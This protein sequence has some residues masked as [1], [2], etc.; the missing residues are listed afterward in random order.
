MNNWE[1]YRKL[2][3]VIKAIR[4]NKETV[5]TILNIASE[6]N[7]ISVVHTTNDE[8]TVFIHTLEGAMAAKEGDWIIRGIKGEYYPCRNDIFEATYE[9]VD[10]EEQNE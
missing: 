4:V 9:S 10:C 5:S 2:P 6:L 8:Y 7:N 3:K 1:C